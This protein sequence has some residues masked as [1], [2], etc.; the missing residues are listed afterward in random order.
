[1]HRIAAAVAATVLAL[2]PGCGG[3]APAPAVPIGN[4]GEPADATS[5]PTSDPTSNPTRPEPAGPDRD[6]DGTGDDYDQCPDEPEDLDGFADDDGCPDPD[7]DV[8]GIM[9]VDDLCPNEPEN[10]NGVD[11]AD[12]CPDKGI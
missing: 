4:T 12:G 2:V 5:D 11:D 9:D 1:M 7:N 10:R 3:K 6:G 8:D